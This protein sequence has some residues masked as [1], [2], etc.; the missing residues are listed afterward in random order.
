MHTLHAVSYNTQKERCE[1][2]KFDKSIK[3]FFYLPVPTVPTLSYLAHLSPLCLS[4][5]NSD[6]IDIKCSVLLSLALENP[7]NIQIKLITEMG[8]GRWHTF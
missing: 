7:T 2:S 6:E 1:H 8:G 4:A 5:L 3:L